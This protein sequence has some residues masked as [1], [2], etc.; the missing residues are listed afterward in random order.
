[1]THTASSARVWAAISISWAPIGVPFSSNEQA[2]HPTSDVNTFGGRWGQR[3][4][5]L[6]LGLRRDLPGAWPSHLP[7]TR[8]WRRS[9]RVPEHVRRAGGRC[10]RG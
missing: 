5:L 2:Q 6:A 9:S 3:G 8:S 1:V 4:Q 7:R 10:R